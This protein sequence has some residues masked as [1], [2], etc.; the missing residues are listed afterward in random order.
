[1]RERFKDVILLA[2]KIKEGAISQEMWGASRSR[3]KM[4]K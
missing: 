3:K 1:M 4:R 2:L